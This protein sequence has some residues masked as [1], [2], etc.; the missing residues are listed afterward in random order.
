LLSLLKRRERDDT[1]VELLC[2]L[3]AR[4][5]ANLVVDQLFDVL[6]SKSVQGVLNKPTKI[7]S[8]Q[9]FE[10]QEELTAQNCSRNVRNI[11]IST[12][13]TRPGFLVKKQRIGKD[14][15]RAQLHLALRN[16][17]TLM[18]LLERFPANAISLLV[19]KML[20]MFDF[21][22]PTTDDQYRD[23]IPKQLLFEYDVAVRTEFDKHPILWDF[24]CLI[25][26]HPS[27]IQRLWALIKSLLAT[28]IALWNTEQ[29]LHP[30]QSRYWHW[31]LT[32]L[33]LCVRVILLHYVHHRVLRYA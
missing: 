17:D 32:L 26:V 14:E 4:F 7:N 11:V 33:S 18:R 10:V 27:E 19:S 31:T 3:I 28:T 8:N 29:A 24:L 1:V 20:Y 5:D 13:V 21:Y 15:K 16:R 30:N 22:L 9:D 25:A 12:R 23:S 2:D 6:F